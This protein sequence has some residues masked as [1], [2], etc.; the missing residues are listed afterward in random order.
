MFELLR[1]KAWNH[2][3]YLKLDISFNNLSENLVFIIGKNLD[4]A[5]AVS[6][7]AGKSVIVDLITDLLFDRTIRRHSPAS[8]IGSFAKHSHGYMA[9]KNSITGDF[10]YIDK[11][12]NHPSRG[13]KVIFR[14]RSGS[15]TER[16]ER[17]TKADTYKVIAEV[18]GISWPTFR[19]RNYFGQRDF[20]RF[21]NV[22]DTKKADIIID[23]K[24]LG[25]LERC[26]KISHDARLKMSKELDELSTSIVSTTDLLDSL[27]ANHQVVLREMQEYDKTCQEQIDSAVE[28][29][30]DLKK[31]R[32]YAGENSK[33]YTNIRDRLAATRDRLQEQE[34][35]ATDIEEAKSRLR[36]SQVN[37][38]SK[39]D[40]YN[41]LTA[42]I[43]EDILKI[44][45]V[46]SAVTKRCG[47]CS[48]PLNESR[49]KATLTKLRKRLKEKKEQKAAIFTEIERLT[50][51]IGELTVQC[52]DLD[53]KGKK[54][55]R[56][57]NKERVLV[58]KLRL[59]EKWRNEARSLLS[60]ID[61]LYKNVDF[62][63]EH[64]RNAPGGRTS[65][66]MVSE[67]TD[68]RGILAKKKKDIAN[69]GS[70]MQKERIS[71]QVYKTSIR[72]LFDEFLRDLNFHS[73]R[74]LASLS[75]SDIELNFEPKTTR[76]S[77]K[78]VDEINVSVVVN[79]AKPRPFRT[80]SGG[81]IGKIEFSTQ[82]A[83]FSAAEV[84]FPILIFDEPFHGV[85]PEGRDRM[86]EILQEMSK[87]TKV[88]V[89]SH[90]E[91][92]SGYGTVL[93]AIRENGES[94]LEGI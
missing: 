58:K 33:E 24:K 13:D 38:S 26:Q 73:S 60:E 8:F 9:I 56:L 43:S 79:G 86:T 55:K 31:K 77:K 74:I 54:L 76:K 50:W 32:D 69:L 92:V 82:I 34:D 20:E 5:G 87:K 75:D 30:F 47:L 37:L 51:D 91:I 39:T 94:R 85:D 68:L 15:V 93:T 71:E 28:K 36:S 67:M 2:V 10:Y 46:K 42:Q 63:R 90:E 14:R 11:F 27:K 6:N 89:I 62:L 12:R 41:G 45:D 49:K 70:E 84:P 4:T 21:L 40:I 66:K 17:K 88:F 78:V 83:L 7:G 1:L 61:S 25:D 53:K 22:T 23:I 81:E 80:Y 52:A 59:A 35:L 18:L 29:V 48:A 72:K 65:A 64:K 19:N 44:R 57:Q 3:Y 16:L